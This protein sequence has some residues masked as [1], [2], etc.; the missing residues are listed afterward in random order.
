[1]YVG[2]TLQQLQDHSYP[3]WTLEELAYH[4]TMM[5]NLQDCLNEQGRQILAKVAAE[6][7]ARGG[8]PRYGGDYD[9][10]GTTIHYE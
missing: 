2:R 6:I 1:M 4:Q 3:E 9:G 5:T 7:E 8:L 10:H